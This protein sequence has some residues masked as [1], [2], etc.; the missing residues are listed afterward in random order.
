M[1]WKE[2]EHICV[3]ESYTQKGTYII[4]TSHDHPE[5]CLG[6]I[7]CMKIRADNVCDDKNKMGITHLRKPF[8]YPRRLIE[9]INKPP[10]IPPDPV[11][12]VSTVETRSCTCLPY[13]KPL[14]RNMRARQQNGFKAIQ[15]AQ[16]TH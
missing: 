9:H 16:T 14:R 7:K 3:Q 1:N 15:Y 2:S 13:I 12:T 6:A 10:D 11:M 4:C 8:G 5:A